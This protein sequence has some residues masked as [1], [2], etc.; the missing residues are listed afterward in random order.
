MTPEEIKDYRKILE[1][2]FIDKDLEIETSLSYISI[3]ALG[4][5]MTINEKF[6]KV[7][8]AEHRIIL[9]FSLICLFLSFILVLI[10]K[11]RSGQNDEKL[12][13]LLVNIRPETDD[14]QALLE[15]WRHCHNNLRWIRI[16]IYYTLGIGI[17]LQVL[18][19]LLNLK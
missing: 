10:R 2:D 11:S 5:F 16:L 4:F 7:E 8:I 14:D 9:I 1:K 19:L 18:F 6:I 12:L 15:L 3:G 17:G 13:R